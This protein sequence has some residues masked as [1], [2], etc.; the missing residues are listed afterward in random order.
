LKPIYKRDPLFPDRQCLA[1]PDNPR[2]LL[3]TQ[4]GIPYYQAHK[5]KL[6]DR[7]LVTVTHTPESMLELFPN[8]IGPQG[9]AHMRTIQDLMFTL[10]PGENEFWWKTTPWK[11]NDRS[12]GKG[13]GEGSFSLAGTIQKGE[14]KG[15]YV[16][17]MQNASPSVRETL[18]KLFSVF[19]KLHRIMHL[20][21]QRADHFMLAEAEQ[22]INNSPRIGDGDGGGTSVQLNIHFSRRP[23]AET[24]G[25]DQAEPHTDEED[26]PCHPTM[27]VHLT[28]T[29]YGE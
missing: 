9:A 15:V 24:I 2:G 16:P 11:D 28:T 26:D 17:A 21:S 3:V 22:E 8:T 10:Q 18:L 19:G 13:T 1:L 4:V 27:T 5:E 12:A 14:G 20:T 29:P 6:R 25:F 23:F 7:T